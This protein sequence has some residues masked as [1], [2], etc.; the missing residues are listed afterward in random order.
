M[1]VEA[2]E[3]GESS[4]S[5]L[6]ES[7]EGDEVDKEDGD[8]E[9]KDDG[10]EGEAAADDGGDAS[11]EEDDPNMDDSIQDEMRKLFKRRRNMANLLHLITVSCTEKYFIKLS[12]WYVSDTSKNMLRQ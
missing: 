2:N 3:E 6:T 9:R 5:L 11:N 8:E 4:E 10:D 7:E 12:Q 1:Q